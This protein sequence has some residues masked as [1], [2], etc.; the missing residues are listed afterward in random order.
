[1]TRAPVLPT[2]RL[3]PSWTITYRTL[4]M[5]Q[6][7]ISVESRYCTRGPLYRG[8]RRLPPLN[9][10]SKNAECS[11]ASV[12]LPSARPAR[13]GQIGQPLFPGRPAASWPLPDA[14]PAPV[15]VQT[16]PDTPAPTAAPWR[17]WPGR[18]AVSRCLA[19]RART[20][21]DLHGNPALRL[22]CTAS[23][24][25][26]ACRFSWPAIAV[27]GLPARAAASAYCGRG[28][29]RPAARNV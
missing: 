15:P 17:P 26:R 9:D 4:R 27:R 21:P 18:R 7:T 12:E 14:R 22:T 23:P 1:M 13:P 20:A 16:C 6:P 19:R 8:P 25:P 10:R 11:S 3:T 5:R 24:P 29:A 2:H 28:H